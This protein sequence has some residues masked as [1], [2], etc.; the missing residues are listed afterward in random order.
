ML[1]GTMLLQQQLQEVRGEVRP[2]AAAVPPTPQ[3][4]SPAVRTGSGAVPARRARA[5][6]ATTSGVT[7]N[8]ATAN[9]SASNGHGAYEEE[10]A[11]W[12]TTS[13]RPAPAPE[14]PLQAPSPVAAREE[15][16]AQ[17]E[18]SNFPTS[19]E[20]SPTMPLP[21]GKIENMATTFQPVPAEVSP[22]LPPRTRRGRA[23][24]A[25][26]AIPFAPAQPSGPLPRQSSPAMPPVHA[27]LSP[28]PAAPAVNHA[29]ASLSSASA[30]LAVKQNENGS[31]V[32]TSDED[33]VIFEQMRHQLIIWLRVEV[34]RAGGEL[35]T[36]N[37][38]QLVDLLRHQDGVDVARVQVVST[39]LNMC[40][41]IINSGHA[42]LFDYKQA[43]MFYLMHTRRGQ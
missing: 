11:T 2:A 12:S 28:T 39:L 15:E 26:S 7:A 17:A 30:E 13:N 32:Q 9:G 40:D 10:A 29:P 35:E 23:G 19:A 14:T 5:T 20:A 42:T 1:S 22:A 24:E 41:Q 33:V 21:L 43:M 8:G 16:L 18:F 36:Q 4:A 27:P 38:Y 25:A 31:A 37:P 3:V 6:R 34:V